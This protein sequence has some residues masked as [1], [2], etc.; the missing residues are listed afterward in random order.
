MEHKILQ[1]ILYVLDLRRRFRERNHASGEITRWHNKSQATDIAACDEESF[2]HSCPFHESF[3]DP[4]EISPQFP[5]SLLNSL[6]E[7][8]AQSIAAVLFVMRLGQHVET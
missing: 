5:R 8:S 3:P 4:L 6:Y 2:C 7:T 1:K